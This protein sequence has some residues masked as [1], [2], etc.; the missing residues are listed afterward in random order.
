MADICERQ[1][2]WHPKNRRL[3]QIPKKGIEYA[4]VSEDYQ[5][6]HQLVWCKDFMQDAIYGQVNQKPVSIY[7][8]KYDPALDP[9]LYM[10]KTRIMVANWHDANFGLKICNCLEF[11]NEV[12]SHLKMS[13]TTI[14][15]CSGVPVVYKKSGV[16]LLEGSKRWMKSPPM[17]SLYTLL[18]RIGLVHQSG[19]NFKKT[20]RLIKSGAIKPY[21]WKKDKV[22][23]LSGKVTHYD[24][25]RDFLRIGNRA[26][27]KILKHGDRKLFFRD[28][29]NNYPKKN[30]R[31]YSFCTHHLHECCGLVG[32][33]KKETELEFPHW[34]RLDKA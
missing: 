29:Q 8:F 19:D 6:I 5:Q 20:I 23:D 15:K 3:I 2:K 33:S 7:G 9:P 31:G 17:M 14:N 13:R 25:D 18:I 22:N 28:I 21:N 27:S 16:W 24:N 26:I 30:K 12:E 4:F 32:F 34:H 1:V 11:L 10:K